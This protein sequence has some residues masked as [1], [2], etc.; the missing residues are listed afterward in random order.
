MV[1][2][3][4]YIIFIALLCLGSAIYMN[5][6]ERKGSVKLRNWYSF[7]NVRRG[8]IP[9]LA[10]IVIILFIVYH[11][12]KSLETTIAIG[13]FLFSIIA[14]GFCQSLFSEYQ[15]KKRGYKNLDDK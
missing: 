15:M 13:L 2:F 11:N 5:H 8:I 1:K 3:I 4:I 9:F 6:I 12:T 14:A 7:K 10:G